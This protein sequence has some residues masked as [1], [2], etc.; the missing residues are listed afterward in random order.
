MGITSSLLRNGAA[1]LV[2]GL[3]SCQ[4]TPTVSTDKGVA[5]A[6]GTTGATSGLSTTACQAPTA[7]LALGTFTPAVKRDPSL[8]SAAIAKANEQTVAMKDNKSTYHTLLLNFSSSLADG[9]VI[10]PDGYWLDVCAQGGS[11]CISQ[12]SGATAFLRQLP[13]NMLS[14]AVRACMRNDRV[15]GGAQGVDQKVFN[16]EQ[17]TCNTKGVQNVYQLGQ[18][19]GDIQ[20]YQSQMVNADN[21]EST[22]RKAGYALQQLMRSKC[23]RLANPRVDFKFL[24]IA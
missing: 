21:A 17:Y 20:A 2:L 4:K 22:F 6:S 1:I 19:S 5:G 7:S 16:G 9:S 12:F 15:S 11:N 8:I 18:N 24:A 13:G 3:A 23:K 10:R 14:V